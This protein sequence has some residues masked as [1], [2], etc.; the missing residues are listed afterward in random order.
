MKST[1]L[2][3]LMLMAAV[4]AQSSLADGAEATLT[5]CGET[6]IEWDFLTTPQHSYST[7]K[8]NGAEW[9]NVGQRIFDPRATREIE[10]E[11]GTF[12][13]V[14]GCSDG[15]CTTSNVLWSPA[16]ACEASNEAAEAAIR[17]QVPRGTL[18]I[19]RHDGTVLRVGYFNEDDNATLAMRITQHNFY[20]A[21]QNI[22]G[23]LG[24]GRENMTPMKLR[25][26]ESPSNIKLAD[27]VY[28]TVFTLY[29][30]L[31]TRQLVSYDGTGVW[32][33][34]KQQLGFD[35]ELLEKALRDAGKGD[36]VV[37]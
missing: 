4:Y 21:M 12:Y 7:Q 36:D 16:L 32:D 37:R 9:Q 35:P 26:I 11:S 31:R 22:E 3:L 1:Y 13:R 24:A 15:I 5:A 10:L 30:N 34:R 2:L 18:T 27:H 17:A 8:W 25:Y 23:M 6:R 33:G 29:E 20:L 19:A 14:Q 28:R